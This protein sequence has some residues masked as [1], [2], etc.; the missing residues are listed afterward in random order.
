MEK[1]TSGSGTLGTIISLLFGAALGFFLIWACDWLLGNIGTVFQLLLMLL[2]FIVSLLV[3]VIL[4]EL[5]HLIFGLFT[6]Y[7]F[8]SFR[9]FN[10]M[11]IKLDGKICFKRLSLAGTAG[12]CLMLP[13]PLKEG[14]IP[15][16]WYN[17]GGALVNLFFSAI[18]LGLV[19]PC[20]E[21]P[22]FALFLLIFGVTG[23]ISGLSNGIPMRV[24]Q[25]D[26]DGKN[27][28]ALR[29]SEGATYAFWLQLQVNGTLAGGTRLKDMPAE[30]FALPSVEEMQ[31]SML[32]TRG[33]FTENY[34]MDCHRF[35]EAK[36]L[37]QLLLSPTCGAI[38]VHQNLLRCDLAYIAL[39][40]DGDK[41]GAQALWTKE[42]VAFQKTM[43]NFPT[44]LRTQ[45]TYALLVERD[46]E[47]A[48]K[49]FAVFEEVA[50]SYPYAV[51]IDAEREFLAIA[52]ERAR[53]EQEQTDIP[54]MR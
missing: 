48:Q 52:Q 44:V 11:W 21:A 18:C 33:V 36:E 26:N 24:G 2:I 16:V 39:A 6:G 30:W 29:K 20:K 23:L 38:G 19:F 3:H 12:Q 10:F 42:L 49:L 35:A 15:T 25:I 41:E 51:D 22:Y 9:I 27:A 4:H 47:K 31:N 7:R 14:K 28:L 5:G 53:V 46:E 32:A 8:S 1:K 40:I 17:L 45:Y 54:C 37:G 43:K 50:K 13:P 34:Y